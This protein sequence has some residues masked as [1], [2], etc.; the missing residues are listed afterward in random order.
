MFNFLTLCL[1]LSSH[2]IPLK[3][4]EFWW[5]VEDVDLI[6]MFDFSYIVYFW[7]FL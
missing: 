6:A 7:Y 2:Q 5:C 3:N 4:Y 1:E